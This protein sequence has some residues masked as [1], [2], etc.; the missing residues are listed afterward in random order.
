MLVVVSST[1]IA[2]IKRGHLK[3]YAMDVSPSRGFLPTHNPIF[4]THPIFGS[5]LFR[6]LAVEQF[7]YTL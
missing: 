6:R 2:K 5:Y 4:D 1:R 7:S 3:I